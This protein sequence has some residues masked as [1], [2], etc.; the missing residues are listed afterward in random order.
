M[1]QDIETETHLRSLSL[2]SSLLVLDPDTESFFKAETGIQDTEELRKQIARVQE[3]AYKVD[4]HPSAYRLCPYGKQHSLVLRFIPTPASVRS[5]S[6]SLGLPR[7]PY[8]HAS[9]HC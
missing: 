7:C 1:D 9:C 4:H 2:D 6:P 5:D 8:T 3:D